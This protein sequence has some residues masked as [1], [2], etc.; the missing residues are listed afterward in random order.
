MRADGSGL[1]RVTRLPAANFAPF[2]HP[3]GERIVF[4]SNVDDPAGRTFALYV[5]HVDGT[6]LERLTWGEGFASFPMWSRNGRRLVF[7]SSRQAATPRELNV[8]VADWVD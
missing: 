8:F 3:D 1:R 2:M 6:G 5:V 7:C 4:A